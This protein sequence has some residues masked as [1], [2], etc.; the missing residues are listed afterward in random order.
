MR[1]NSRGC[2]GRRITDGGGQCVVGNGCLVASSRAD[3]QGG[4][5]AHLSWW[6]GDLIDLPCLPVVSRGRAWY[7]QLCP[8][9]TTTIHKASDNLRS[10]GGGAVGTSG[11]QRASAQPS[12]ASGVGFLDL[13]VVVSGWTKAVQSGH[14]WCY[15]CGCPMAKKGKLG[16]RN[17]GL[18][19]RLIW[20]ATSVSRTVAEWSGCP[21]T[22][23]WPCVAGTT[24]VGERN[25]GRVQQENTHSQP[26]VI[27]V[28]DE[29]K[30]GE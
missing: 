10:F 20:Y 23:L 26:V 15:L 5:W 16:V 25:N 1:P 13:V 2:A 14:Q 29:D 7:L 18:G 24:R 8:G 3:A 4:F 12:G 6:C 27:Y 9:H 22:L 11:G 28:A 21:G 19:L 17:L 30:E